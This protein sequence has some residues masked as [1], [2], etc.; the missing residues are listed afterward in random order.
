VVQTLLQHGADI[1]STDKDGSTSLHKA[2]WFGHAAVVQTLL[3]HG[4]DI[5]ST[6]KDGSTSLHEASSSGHAAV[7]QTLLQHG[8]DIAATDQYG[9]TPLDLYAKYCYDEVKK[10]EVKAVF[11]KHSLLLAAQVG[12]AELAP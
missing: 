4:A 6:D 1:E 8:A 5:E 11:A 12:T 2:S 9:K 10:E 3:Q 7:V